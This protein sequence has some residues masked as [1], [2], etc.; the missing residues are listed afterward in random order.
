[1]RSMM[2]NGHLARAVADVGMPEFGRQLTYEAAMTGA[3][4]AVA[5]RWFPSS[6]T[7]ADCGHVPAGLTLSDREWI[8]EEWGVIPDRDRIAAV[9]LMKFATS[10]AVSACGEEGS[11]VGRVAAVTGLCEPET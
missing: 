11:D 5:D 10:S 2:A 7:G 6:K 4:I 9:N 3:S 8:D 1:M